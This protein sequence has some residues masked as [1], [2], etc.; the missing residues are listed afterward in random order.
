[1]EKDSCSFVYTVRQQIYKKKFSSEMF[2]TQR[3]RLKHRETSF[4]LFSQ[5][6]PYAAFSS[7]C[8]N[9]Q[10]IRKQPNTTLWKNLWQTSHISEIFSNVPLFQYSSFTKLSSKQYSSSVNLSFQV[11]CQRGIVDLEFEELKKQCGTRY[12]RN[13][14]L[15]YST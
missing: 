1:M 2:C 9:I 3:D 7:S 11:S 10:F 14:V 13:R 8:F 6:Q 12:C 15:L 5:S 4:I